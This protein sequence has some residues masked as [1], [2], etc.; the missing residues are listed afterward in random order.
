VALAALV[1]ATASAHVERASYWPDP[2]PDTSVHPPT[3]GHVPAPR[4][5]YS[6]LRKAPP[7]K[8]RVV[9]QGRVPSSKR[10]RKL[11]R[12]LRAARRAHASRVRIKRLRKKLARAKRRYKRGVRRNA[13]IRAL[14]KAIAK[15]RTKGYEY[16]PT[17]RTRFVSR[18]GG[19]RLHRFNERLLARCKYHEIQPAVM[20]AR[21]ND[22][23][24]IMPGVY[25][26]PSA[27]AKPNLDPKCK[28]Y[29]IL[30]DR[31]ERTALSYAYQ[32]Y[33]PNAQNLVAV[34]GRLPGPGSDPKE[35]RWDR[36]GIPNLGR[37]IRCNLQLEG[38][39]PSPDDVVI[40][41][42]RVAS[43]NGAPIGAKKDVGVRAD[44]A[45]GFVLRNMTVRHAGEHAIYVME[46]DGYRL[47]RFKA[48]YSGEYGVLTFVEDHGLMQDC[49]AAGHGDAALYPGAAAETGEQ[50]VEKT[51]R[52]NQ[53]LRR[54]DMRHSVQGYSGTA[55]NAV[56][57]HHNNFYDN[58]EGFT[59]DVVTAAGHPGYPQ[60]SDLIENNRFYSNNFNPYQEGSDVE[61]SLLVP[62]GTALNVAGGNNNTIRNN[63]FYDNWRRGTM[64]LTV[65]DSFVCG[66]NPVAGGNHQAG[67]KEDGSTTTS[68]DNRF[69]DNVMGRD[70]SG[71]RDPNGTDFWW[72]SY[73]NQQHH[74]PPTTTGNCWFE[75]TG[76]DGT[77]GSITSDPSSLPSDCD[78]SLG[79]GNP[80]ESELIACF[81]A[82][83]G[84]DVGQCPWSKTPPEPK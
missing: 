66:D 18:R 48:Y 77:E 64:L 83:T 72:D 28:K 71:K 67:C 14:R 33:C 61:P 40:D 42:G 80:G 15:A 58:A 32:Y 9:C 5:L 27:R 4:G 69:H 36:H 12:R 22:R 56:W 75:N 31:G 63:Y 51:R 6:A 26:E 76:K 16:R 3:G 47:E 55:G 37:C 30:N 52:Y 50:T 57:V 13:S 1:A 53:E 7:G 45:D 82:F 39:G 79:T 34:M 24:V 54:C 84:T 73:P 68:F 44:R 65:P 70:P 38:S 29:E 19:R 25:S 35:P 46:A 78:A 49:D 20:A 10:V 62:T 8:T 41:A 74:D 17:D 11:R 59:T 43:G 2:K 23:V 60:D 81:A 21:N